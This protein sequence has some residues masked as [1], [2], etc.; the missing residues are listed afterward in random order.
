MVW[1][2]L[3][4]VLLLALSLPGIWVQ[5]VLKRYSGHRPDFPGNGGDMARHLLAQLDI[6]DVAVET[7]DQ[8]DHY[9]PQAKA[10]RLTADKFEGKSLTAVVVAA[11]AAAAAHTARHPGQLHV[12]APS[13]Q[14]QQLVVPA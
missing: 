10:V 6:R 8:G 1:L 13:W 14:L 4:L 9:D 3:F 5:R 2:V 7:T 12:M 11:P